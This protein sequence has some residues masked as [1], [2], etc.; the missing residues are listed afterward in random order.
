[1][2]SK[3]RLTMRHIRQ[4]LRLSAGGTSVREIAVMLGI[5]RSTVQDN[6]DR[7]KTAGLIWPL[8]G[9]LT[10]DALEHRLFSRAG[11]KQGQRRREE[12]SWAELS[13]ELKKPGV[14]LLILWEEYRSV[15][16]DGYGYSRFCE[17]FRGFEQRLSPTMR[18][19]HAAGDKVF[20]DYSGKK[21][22]IVDRKTGEVR[23][24]ELFLGVL[25]A[26]SYTFAEAT[27]TQTL[28]DWIGSHGRM[29]AFFGGVPRLI[30]PDNLKSGVSRASFYDPEIN[31]SYGRMASHYGVGVLPA[32]PR[33][34]KDKAKVENGVRFAQ[35]CILGR[36]RKQTFFSLAEANAAIAGV[37][38]RINNHVMRRLGVSRRQLFEAVERA[39]L[40]SLPAED[41]EFAEW[42][43]ARVSTDYHVEFQSF[44]Y[45]VPHG[46]IRQ[47]VDIRATARM[48]EIFHRGERIAVHQRRYGGKRY[49]TDPA[50]MPSSHR[51][52]AEW[53][54]DRF[55]RWGASI[56]P[57][58][59][60][61]ITA[62]LAS[63]PHPEQGFRTCLGIL[64]LYRDI[65]RERAETVS[66]R[67]V[68][69]GG[70]T[71][72]TIASLIYTQKRAG[73][74]T[75]PAAVMEHANL[76]GPGYFH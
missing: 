60:G 35:S 43:F 59:E 70:L 3:R 39:A 12:P 22:P 66:A 21:V 23:E 17:L 76:R 25:G 73:Q 36:L 72:K 9:E 57:Q 65:S 29:F 10:D 51:R 31:R 13:I 41:Y 63:R 54:P 30:V 56:G 67:A 58:T 27:W 47:Q 64:R 75:E 48:I 55:R 19:E 68:E 18:Q 34:P 8:P 50:H 14:T 38:E 28:P 11:V 4:M 42:R 69:I 26:S 16:P 5:A 62:I 53:T 45:S 44:F 2:P 32:R 52:Y 6:L 71:C 1:M 20:V 15:H 24:A 33:R 7:A 46:L 37:L 61:L 49:G 74:S 40:A